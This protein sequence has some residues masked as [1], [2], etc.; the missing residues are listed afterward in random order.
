MSGRR[1]SSF[2]EDTIV[3]F[4][5]FIG[6]GAIV[7]GLIL[8]L[9]FP[10]ESQILIDSTIVATATSSSAITSDADPQPWLIDGAAVPRVVCRTPDD[11]LKAGTG[12]WLDEHRV[13]VASHVVSGRRCWVNGHPAPILLDDKRND[14]AIIGGDNVGGV[15]AERSCAGPR[16]GE[17]YYVTGYAGGQWLRILPVV[18]TSLRSDHRDFNGAVVFYGGRR[19]ISGASGGP[20][21]GSDG[22]I[23]AMTEAVSWFDPPKVG[24]TTTLGRS[25]ADT[26]LCRGKPA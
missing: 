23:Y 1:Q 9:A 14:F 19:D 26:T 13:A 25:L 8:R 10:P 15:V 6:I 5:C 7:L 17:L 4:V 12:F 2:V 18:A 22:V 16:A 11:K 3:D 20:I 24:P 21:I